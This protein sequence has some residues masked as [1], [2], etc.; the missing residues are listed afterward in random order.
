MPELLP[1][2]GDVLE[3]IVDQMAFPRGGGVVSGDVLLYLAP[4]DHERDG[5]EIIIRTAAIWNRDLDMLDHVRRSLVRNAHR[6]LQAAAA[7]T[8]EELLAKLDAALAED[9]AQAPYRG[10]M[11]H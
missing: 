11:G 5:A 10:R 2:P 8:E 3:V 7:L 9:E 6:R 1:E 4:E